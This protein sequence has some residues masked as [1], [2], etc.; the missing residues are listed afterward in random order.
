MAEAIAERHDLAQH[1]DGLR[2]EPHRPFVAPQH[3]GK[4]LPLLKHAA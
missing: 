1:G 3:R 2:I 4:I